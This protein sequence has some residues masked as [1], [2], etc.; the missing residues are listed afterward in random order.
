MDVSMPVL[1]GVEAT[2]QLRRVSPASQ[3]V[4]LTM[5]A[6]GDVMARAIQAGAIGYLVKDCSTEDVVAA[7]RQAASGE[8]ILS[9]ELANS[10]LTEVKKEAAGTA[11]GTAPMISARE[12]EVLQLIADGLSLPEVSARL[13]ISTKTVKNHL[14]SI[15]AKLDAR[16]RTQAVLRA[17]RMGL[18]RLN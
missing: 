16:D 14:A 4:M 3:V 1:D 11:K 5:H 18:I 10:M 12:E 7:V 17:V 6:D 8:S 9:S 15:Y 2:K 13:Y